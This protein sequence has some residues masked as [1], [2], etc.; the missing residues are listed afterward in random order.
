M[1]WFIIN[2]LNFL[3]TV[4][5]CWN[6]YK[7]QHYEHFH[8]L[9]A[10]LS[11]LFRFAALDGS[12]L[13]HPNDQFAA[14]SPWI[15]RLRLKLNLKSSNFN[16]YLFLKSK[17]RNIFHLLLHLHHKS[18]TGSSIQPRRPPNCAIHQTF[19]EFLSVFFPFKKGLPNQNSRK[20]ISKVQKLE[21]EKFQVHF[22]LIFL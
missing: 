12:S 7:H 17:D 14:Q 4:R 15:W 21:T 5:L 8:I 18:W 13:L 1:K 10:V 19:F 3:F 11:R 2:S 20:M 22:F 6:E 9:S 16:F